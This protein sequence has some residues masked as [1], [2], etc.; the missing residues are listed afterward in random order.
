MEDIR[1]TMNHVID[2]F[3]E[4]SRENPSKKHDIRVPIQKA[5]SNHAQ[6]VNLVYI[7]GNLQPDQLLDFVVQCLVKH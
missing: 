4:T 3:I 5:I 2:E 1:I 7:V 6:N